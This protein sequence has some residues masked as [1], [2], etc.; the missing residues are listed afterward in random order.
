MR[1]PNAGACRVAPEKVTRY[2]LDPDHSRGASK[3]AFFQRFGF[4]TASWRDLADALRE[5]AARQPVAKVVDTAYGRRFLLQCRLTSPDGR[6]PCVVTVW[7]LG[8]DG[9]PFLVTAYPR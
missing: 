3:A 8:P 9:E 4:T 2:L 5:H 1:L 7:Q 6:D